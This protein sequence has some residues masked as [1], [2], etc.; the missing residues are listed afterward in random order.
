VRDYQKS[1]TVSKQ[2]PRLVEQRRAGQSERCANVHRIANPA[3]WTDNHEVA[4]RV[5]WRRRPATD[6]NERGDTPQSQGGAACSNKRTGD[7]RGADAGR[8]GDSGPREN[9]SREEHQEETDKKAGVRNRANENERDSL[10]NT[11]KSKMPDGRCR[12]KPR[13]LRYPGSSA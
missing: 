2:C 1:G 13:Q 5:K 7:L 11:R 3:I 6:D 4:G 12:V 8:S 9:A 10:P